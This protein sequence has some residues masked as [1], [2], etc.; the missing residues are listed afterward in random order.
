VKEDRVQC[1]AN[2]SG[3]DGVGERWAGVRKQR[4]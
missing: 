1:R 2:R 3:K 4:E